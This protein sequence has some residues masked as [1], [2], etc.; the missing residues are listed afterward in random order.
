MES[1]VALAAERRRDAVDG[2]HLLSALTQATEGIPAEI[3]TRYGA[4]L[5]ALRSLLT[6][7]T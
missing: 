5:P 6:Q 3:L 4:S 1:A 2:F 7:W